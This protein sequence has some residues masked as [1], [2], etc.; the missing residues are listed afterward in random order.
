MA[1]RLHALSLAAMTIS[2]DDDSSGDDAEES[3]GG[4]EA[5]GRHRG[6]GEGISDAAVKEDVKAG[7]VGGLVLKKCSPAAKSQ[8]RRWARAA[9]VGGMSA[10]KMRGCSWSL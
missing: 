7:G 4:A 3:G 9:G 10:C 5:Q 6:A 8:M 2:E 1:G